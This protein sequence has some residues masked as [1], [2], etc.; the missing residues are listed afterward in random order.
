MVCYHDTRRHKPNPDPM[1][2]G[3]NEL[4]L[5]ADQVIS[6]GDTCAD[7]KSSRSAGIRSIGALWGSLEC[8]KLAAAHPNRLC[9][10]VRELAACLGAV[11]K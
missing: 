5:G 10:S 2:Q 1:L 9:N 3:L 11:K 4:G 7:I 8:D 6:V